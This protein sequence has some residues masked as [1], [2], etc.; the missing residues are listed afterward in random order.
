MYI[1]VISPSERTELS[2]EDLKLLRVGLGLIVM[3]S[4]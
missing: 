1:K 4:L 3:G 2:E